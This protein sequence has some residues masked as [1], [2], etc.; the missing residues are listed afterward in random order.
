L[1]S[2]Q[3]VAQS[4]QFHRITDEA[5][6]TSC[7]GRNFGGLVSDYKGSNLTGMYHT[8]H[9]NQLKNNGFFYQ[10]RRSCR[11]IFSKASLVSV[12]VASNST[13]YCSTARCIRPTGNSSTRRPVDDC[14]RL[15]SSIQSPRRTAIS[16]DTAWTLFWSLKGG[17]Y[18]QGMS[19][20]H[21]KLRDNIHGI[22]TSHVTRPIP[23]GM[24]RHTVPRSAEPSQM[25]TPPCW[26]AK[27]SPE[28]SQCALTIQLR[29]GS[30]KKKTKLTQRECTL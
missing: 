28:E 19:H 27:I 30:P 23:L 10:F 17:T 4:I 6:V 5:P 15:A 9:V 14:G 22:H 8:C 13:R 12:R 2:R 1:T 21:K 16:E 20:L 3:S 7:R 11:L 24:G 26:L 18:N 29:Y 25:V